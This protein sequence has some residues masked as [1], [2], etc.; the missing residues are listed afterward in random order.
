MVSRRKRSNSSVGNKLNNLTD[1][2]TEQQKLQ[3][4]SGTQTNAVTNDSIALGAVNTESVSDRSITSAKIGRG[5]VTSEN[6]G[7]INEIIASDGLD[8]ET[9]VDGHLSLSG[10]KYEAPYD[11]IDDGLDYKVVAFDPTNNTIKVIDAYPPAESGL[12]FDTTYTEGST[13]VGMLSWN[14]EDETLEV[15]VGNGEVT[16]Q[17]GQEFHVR[18]H[19]SNGFAIP[20]G[21]VVYL[22]GG[23]DAHGHPYVAPYL[24]DGTTSPFRVLGITTQEIPHGGEGIVTAKGLIRGLDTSAYNDGQVLYASTTSFGGFQTT[25][26][27]APQDTVAVGTVTVSDATDGEIYVTVGPQLNQLKTNLSFFPTTVESDVSGYY[28]MV[29]STVDPDYDNPAVDVPIP[30]TGYLNTGTGILVGTVIADANEFVGNPGE[31]EMTITGNIGK[32]HGNANTSA[33]FYYRVYKRTSGGTET[34]LGESNKTV[35]T[36]FSEA[37]PIDPAQF[38]ALATVVFSAFEATDRLVVKFYADVIEDGDQ[39]YTFMYG[40]TTPVRVLLPIPASSS[41]TSEIP[42][43]HNYLIN[44]GMDIWQRGTS[45]TTTNDGYMAD[46]W[47]LNKN[48]TCNVSQISSGLPSG[49]TYGMQLDATTSSDFNYIYQALERDTV[50]SLRGKTMTFSAY[51]LM[52]AGMRAL[53][54]PFELVVDYSTSTDAV[55]SQTVSVAVSPLDMADYETWALAS[56]T[57]AVPA[58]AVGL[59][60]GIEPPVTSVTTTAASYSITKLQLEEGPYAT[61]FRRHGPGIQAELAACQRYYVRFSSQSATGVDY[62]PSSGTYTGTTTA[63]NIIQFPVPMRA[64]PASGAVSSAAHFTIVSANNDTSTAVT[65]QS[66]NSSTY[67]A[68]VDFTSGTAR[69]QGFSTLIR[70]NNTAGWLEINAEL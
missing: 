57:F 11:S 28:R 52:D 4:V 1:K 16:L 36:V 42:T 47:Y 62:I 5:E 26:P 65:Y 31:I 23:A 70:F 6:L 40:G 13:A 41:T 58:D 64:I 60:V 45:F 15:Q 14:T 38:V 19:N 39:A 68:R 10:G 29:N 48:G 24:A 46:R 51:I 37:A 59:R 8:I 9:G 53:T 49:V 33:S 50:T 25:M 3:Q 61:P 20:D 55:S 32:T 22:F 66:A 27:S 34:L 67:A 63:T 43:S 56:V 54:D 35:S 21:T 7:V 44:G 69:T 12:R 17:I 18:V 2:V 30:S